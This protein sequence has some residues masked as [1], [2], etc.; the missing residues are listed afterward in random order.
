MT[1]GDGRPFRIIPLIIEGL[2]EAA[3]KHPTR[4]IRAHARH[5]SQSADT[6]K[7]TATCLGLKSFVRQRQQ[8]ITNAAK[9][10]KVGPMQ[11]VH[12]ITEKLHAEKLSVNSQSF[13]G[14]EDF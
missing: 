12:F 4:S 3:A 5:L 8:L 11:V 13:L 6:V 1:I 14:Q 2:V 10:K 7:R 9:V